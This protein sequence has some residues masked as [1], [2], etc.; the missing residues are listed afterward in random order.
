MDRNQTGQHPF[1]RMSHPTPTTLC[2]KSRWV[3][4]NGPLKRKVLAQWF[5]KSVYP[6]E[7]GF[8]M[9]CIESVPPP[10]GSCSPR[11]LGTP[12]SFPPMLWPSGPAP[13]PSAPSSRQPLTS[14]AGNSTT[15]I[16]L[17]RGRMAR[18]R[19]GPHAALA[20]DEAEG[21][22]GGLGEPKGEARGRSTQTWLVGACPSRSSRGSEQARLLKHA[23]GN[24]KFI[25][26]VQH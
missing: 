6:Q 15:L 21:H 16:L 24:P 13:L 4:R 20:R 23:Q 26:L 17:P 12:R 19:R 14:G 3:C 5:C 25:K 10:G 11:P 2:L 18:A 1:G 8:N 22:G 9:S 7:F